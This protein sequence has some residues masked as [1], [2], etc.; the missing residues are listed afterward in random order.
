MAITAAMRTTVTQLYAALFNRAPDSDGLGYWCQQLDSGKSTSTV[1]KEMYDT[2]PARTYYPLWF[3]N[4]E[5][6]GQFYTNLLGRTADT[7]GK[8]YWAGEL[9]TKPL[10]EVL[11]NFLNAVVSYAS[12]PTAVGYDAT[13]D[14]QALASQSLFNNKVEVGQ[15]FA[16]TLR[17]NDT[18]LAA[19]VLAQ[20]TSDA[21]SVTTAKAAADAGVT[22]VT[23]AQTFTLTNAVNSFSGAAG[24][25]IFN[26]ILSDG[27]GTF[28]AGDELHGGSGTDTV[29][30]LIASATAAPMVTMSGVE[31]MNIR[32]L[33][34]S[35]AASVN[36]TLFTGVVTITNASS[37]ED[38]QLNVSGVS[39][40]T[41]F[42]LYDEGDL[43]VQFA[44]LTGTNTASLSLVSAG[45]GSGTTAIDAIAVD[46]DKGG[47]GLLGAVNIALSGSNYVNLDGGADLRTVNITGGATADF[48]VFT[49]TA[50]NLLSTIDASATVSTN[51]F[52]VSGRSDVTITGG[53]GNDTFTLGTSLSNGDSISGGS[54]TDS[55]TATLGAAT[56][57]LNT[58]GVESATITYGAAGGGNIDASGTTVSTINLAASLSASGSVSNLGNGVTVN[59]SDDDIDAFGIDTTASATVTLNLGSGASGPVSVSGI[60]VTDAMSATINAIGSGL[61][62]AG[63]VVFDTDAKSLTITV[64]GGESDLLFT[65]LQIPKGTAV[66]ITSNGSAGITF[67]SGLEAA[68]ALQTLTVVAQGTDAADVTFGALFISGAPTALATLSLT[69]TSGADVTVG[70]TNFGPAGVTSNGSTTITMSAGNG[71]VVGTS[72]FD[73][74][75]T[76]VALTLTLD[77]QASGTIGV[78]DLNLVAG[79]NGTGGSLAIGN[80]TLGANATVRVE[81]INLAT[82]NAL[83]FGTL[84][85]GTTAALTIGA[86]GISAANGAVI[87]AIDLVIGEDGNLTFGDINATV[88]SV[89]AITVNASAA[90][91]TA[92]FANIVASAIGQIDITIGT[93]A[94]VDFDVL[95]SASTVLTGITVRIGTDGSADFGNVLVSAGNVGDITLNVGASG[96]VDF[97]NIGASGVGVIYVSGAGVVD[98][99]TV[100]AT[101]VAGID[102]R[103]QL[104]AGTFDIDLSG[105]TNAV[106]TDS[107]PGTNTIV[108]GKGDDIFN[109]KTGLGTDSITFS[110]TAQKADQVYRFE[111]GTADD[112]IMFN[113]S[114]LSAAGI[115]LN[116]ASSTAAAIGT[117]TVAIDLALVSAAVTLAAGDNV[118]VLRSGT[119]SAVGSAVSAIATG[120]SMLITMGSATAGHMLVVWSDGSDS[121]VSTVALAANATGFA[122]AA[123]TET[124]IT[125][126]GVD[127][128]SAAP[129]AGNFDFV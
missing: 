55:I 59:L 19:S 34:T 20:V 101:N 8:A 67:T 43:S 45:S 14:A 12:D 94:G 22:P 104:T 49:F 86:S 44:G 35:A 37:L 82:G 85:V 62:T 48:N 7:D 63:I 88:G 117:G 92:D 56:V 29:N 108:S 119:F 3:S 121:Y 80:T 114:A 2:T 73:V 87:S 112:K 129:V 64:S 57:K 79:T 21:S 28:T 77:A 91:A 47:T 58:T 125:I 84:T 31:T 54:G 30:L 18:T 99:D 66:S 103:Y 39:A 122:S 113:V 105:V 13:L 6:A 102:L 123:S 70:A 51:R 25:D 17:S 78:G 15:Y 50:T 71:S 1:A 68:S 42:T 69:G 23:S 96:S 40:G 61:N 11:T 27:S 60:A 83:N 65:D 116:A 32:Y 98:F 126:V 109:L 33:D 9:N 76:G 127:I 72:A 115:S 93:A 106:T 111:M 100:S 95:G 38:T 124:L 46:L 41:T 74:S 16:E 97:A 52:F 128:T 5:I 90:S 81:Q 24:N 120:G 4:E 53:A 10:G 110:S 75:A 89:G 36:G 107:G 26:G 118:I